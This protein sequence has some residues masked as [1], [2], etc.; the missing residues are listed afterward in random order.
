M[1]YV[2]SELVVVGSPRAAQA[3]IENSKLIEVILS[4]SK[5]ILLNSMAISDAI[6]FHRTWEA[7]VSL[8]GCFGRCFTF[9]SMIW[10][11]D[12]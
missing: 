3:A 9:S 5:L 11:K 12:I 4:N 8:H 6:V 7:S 2:S 10:I 1:S